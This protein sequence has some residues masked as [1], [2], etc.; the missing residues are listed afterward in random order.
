MKMVEKFIFLCYSY[1][2]KE[3]DEFRLVKEVKRVKKKVY[4]IIP[5]I[6]IPLSCL[7]CELL[8]N[9]NVFNKSQITFATVLFLNAA[10]IGNLT[11]TK[12]KFDIVM[13]VVMP[14]TFCLFMLLC[15]FLEEGETIA[16]FDFR[17]AFK[18]AFQN[19]SWVIYFGLAAITFCASYKPLRLYKRKKQ[20]A[21]D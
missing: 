10:V 1:S 11:P 4:Y 20:E 6:S 3:Q 2:V 15:G 13:T 12:R 19:I 16:R 18:I 8:G 9:L 17:H 5:F 14:L 21:T 7:L